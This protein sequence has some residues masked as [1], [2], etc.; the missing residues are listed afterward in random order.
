MNFRPVPLPAPAPGGPPAL[1]PGA[2]TPPPPPPAAGPGGVGPV[3]PAAAGAAPA[4]P[5]GGFPGGGGNPG[6][7]A[8]GVPAKVNPV[9]VLQTQTYDLDD[10]QVLDTKGKQVDKKELAKLLKE[11]KVAMASLYGQPVDPL[12]LRVLKDDI[13]TFV[14]PAPKPRF[15]VP[16]QPGLVPPGFAP[17]NVP[18]AAPG[19]PPAGGTS[20]P[21]AR[22]APANPGG[23]VPPPANLKPPSS[24][25]S[26]DEGV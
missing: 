20:G 26:S 11:E 22:F 24:G 5:Q 17:P 15:G 23:P 2:L 6:P 25:G 21:P 10:V 19:F 7:G 1:P 14:L 16:G 4:A 3:P 12:H 8:G 18:G 9:F 13:L